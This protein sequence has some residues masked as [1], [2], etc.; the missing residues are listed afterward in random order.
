MQLT[1]GGGRRLAE[2]LPLG[3]LTQLADVKGLDRPE[4]AHDPRPHLAILV[5]TLRFAAR[6][7]EVFAG[8]V[9]VRWADT[10]RWRDGDVGGAPGG[11]R[12][13]HQ[14][15]AG[16]RAGHGLAHV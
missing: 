13:A 14:L 12:A 10:K 7:G 8:N 4:V 5:P 15:L 9:A 6:A 16:L 3:E 11:Q 1:M 2:V